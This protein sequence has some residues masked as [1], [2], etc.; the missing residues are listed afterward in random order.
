M[1][2]INTAR[3][4][5]TPGR[6]FP[7]G[8]V[9]Y[10]TGIRFSV[11]SRHA[12]R[13]TIAIFENIQDDTPAWEYEFDRERHRTGDIWSIFVRNLPD[14]VYY[15]Y[16]MDGPYEPGAGHRFRPD[17]YLLDPY[18]KA[19]A[20]D[21]HDGTMKCVVVH[22]TLG[23]LDSARPRTPL[24]ESIIYET[25]V[26]GF[27]V[28]PSSGVA[29]G[30]AYAGLVEKI[31]YLLDLGVTAVELLP[32]Q[33]FG[34]SW[35]GRCSIETREELKN[36]WGYSNV[37]FFAPAGRYACSAVNREHVDEFREMVRALHQ[38]GLEV[39]LD[40]VFNHTSEGSALG[41]TLSFRGIDNSIYY[42]LDEQG[43]YLNFSG[44]GNTVNCNHP[45]VQDF[46]IDCL[47]YWVAAMH[48]DGF[49]FDLASIFG[50][51][52][53]GRLHFETPLI[54]RIAEDPVLHD[55]K[56][57]AEAWDAGG[58]YQVGAFGNTRW[59]E[60]NGRYRDD[61]RRYW[62][63]DAGVR[64]AFASRLSG[65]SDLYADDGRTPAH[66]I[67]FITC[68]DGFTLRDL[69]SYNEKHNLA[70][71]ENNRD[72][73]NE[74]YS[75]N[76]GVEGETD[77]PSVNAMRRRMQKNFL[78]TL[79]VSIGAP[80]LLGGNEFGRT[81]KGNNNAYCQDNEVSWF[82]WSLV[83]DNADLLAFCRGV[84][85]FR[86]D[87]PVFQRTTFFT[88]QPER[89]GDE[90]DLVWV[91]PRGN[92]PDWGSPATPLGCVIGAAQNGGT[93][94]CLLFNNTRETV[95]FVLPPGRWTLRVSTAAPSPYDL[96][97]P[98]PKR[99]RWLRVQTLLTPRSM[100]VLS[101]REEEDTSA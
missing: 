36:Y 19:F 68:H 60:W 43:D 46:I 52:R 49:R 44:C 32:I 59:A 72:G 96:V 69:V 71:G 16:R 34:E 64:G 93:R 27:T 20:G 48:V 80:M 18:A 66:S 37:G 8:A 56:L 85:R 47:R 41:P 15:K 90:P 77:A 63:G 13:V 12:T 75:D 50:R 54:E 14:G 22:D 2:P 83:Q 26:R 101:Q 65:S 5:V 31:P 4:R 61:V 58:A 100:L 88:G 76:C 24:A 94:L 98:V 10:E 39:I 87:N 35:L 28:H 17:A 33:E 7:L 53:K 42:I 99:A 21:I 92:T 11:F 38:A 51:D 97:H 9:V 62:R 45:V 95:P 79:F 82:D 78:T 74:N 3:L 40:V 70:N 23:W 25:H 6:L 29:H 91:D 57:I 67:N 89:E 30:G 84:I 1:P 55:A 86:K 73:S 81:Q